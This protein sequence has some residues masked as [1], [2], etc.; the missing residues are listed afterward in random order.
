VANQS[1]S[2]S[3]RPLAGGGCQ[4]VLSAD[5]VEKPAI[6]QKG[7]L[8]KRSTFKWP[9]SV[10][11]KFCRIKPGNSFPVYSSPTFQSNINISSFV[12]DEISEGLQGGTDRITLVMMVSINF[13]QS[14]SP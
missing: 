14:G 8:D 13:P 12:K 3:E 1:G 5:A 10:P 4:H 7:S 6:W 11:Q 2:Y 9:E